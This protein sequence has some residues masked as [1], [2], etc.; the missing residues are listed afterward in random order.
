MIIFA[1]GGPNFTIGKENFS[2]GSHTLTVIISAKGVQPF[3]TRLGFQ[4]CH[5][6]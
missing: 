6:A 1:I 2:T 4:G 5:N 3:T